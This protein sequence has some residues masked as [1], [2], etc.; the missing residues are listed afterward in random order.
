[1]QSRIS[2]STANVL[3]ECE[4]KIDVGIPAPVRGCRGIDASPYGS[5]NVVACILPARHEP[6]SWVSC[7]VYRAHNRG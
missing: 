5:K 2:L 3:V 1:M 4:G 7:I 6:F